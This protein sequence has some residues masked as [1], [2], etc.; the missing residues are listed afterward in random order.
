L[1][2][3]SLRPHHGFNPRPRRLSTPT[4][5]FQ[6][7][8]DI[9][10]YRTALNPGW[11]NGNFCAAH[12]AGGATA[13]AGAACSCFDSAED[14]AGEPTREEYDGATAEATKALEEAVIGI[15]E[16]LQ[17]LKYELAE[18]REEEEEE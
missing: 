2:G 1:P 8:P 18:M 15:N 6:L 14:G 13:A 17:E 12:D 11:A 16:A 3:V 9:R 4:D 5:A 7:H 10:S